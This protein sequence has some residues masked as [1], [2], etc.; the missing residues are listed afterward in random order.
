VLGGGE[1]DGWWVRPC[2]GYH[3]REPNARR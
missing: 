3:L 1:D 2:D